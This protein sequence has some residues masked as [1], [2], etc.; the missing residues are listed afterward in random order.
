[1]LQVITVHWL[2]VYYFL[3]F[4]SFSECYNSRTDTLMQCYG[5]EYLIFLFVVLYCTVF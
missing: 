3:S 2:L 5:L 4:S 1:M